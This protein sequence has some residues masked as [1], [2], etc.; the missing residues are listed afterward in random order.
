MRP[1][2]SLTIPV[3]LA[4][5]LTSVLAAPVAGSP[6]E[7]AAAAR[8]EHQR[9]VAYWTPER[10][11]SAKPRDLQL[12]GSPIIPNAKP[13][14]T[15]GGGGG[16]G[17]GDGDG[18]VKGAS[19]TKGGDVLKKTG[20]VYFTLSGGNW[21]CS[22]STTTDGNRAGYSLVLTAGHCA[23]DETTGA[24]ATNWLF[25]PDWDS[26]PASF[27][28]A[29]NS[30]AT[31]YGCWTASALVVHAG[32]RY[33]GGFNTQ[34]I[35]YDWAFAVVGPGGYGGTQLDALGAFGIQFSGVSS[36]DRLAAFG[37]PAAGKYKGNDLVWCAGDIFQDPYNSAGSTW[38]M[39]CDMT[40]GSSG[41]PW[42]AGF[43]ESN[44]SGGTQSSLNSYGY[45]SLK[46]YMFGPK[47]NSATESTYNAAKNA[48]TSNVTVGTAP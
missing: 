39:A 14:G 10:M 17:G 21:Q 4:L 33:A 32:F 5:L 2:A 25:I 6:G 48:T 15:P 26:K 41:G 34:A 16:G 31:A 36:G 30:G 12:A 37:Y 19:W 43:N 40:G 18:A 13:P 44:G 47:F 28:T 22:G 45:S 46:G 35:S 7:A 11:A 24:F 42:L 3:G 23:V 9:I 38:G 8:A 1:R 29:C 27:S 20:K